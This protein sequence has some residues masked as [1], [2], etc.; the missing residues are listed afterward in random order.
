[1]EDPES[2]DEQALMSDI[3]NFGWKVFYDEDTDT[4]TITDYDCGCRP[5]L[6]PHPT[7]EAHDDAGQR[8]MEQHYGPRGDGHYADND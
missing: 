5:P 8:W 7:P 2:L 1:M 6:E 4:T 3:E